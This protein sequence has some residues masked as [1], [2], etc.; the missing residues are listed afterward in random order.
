MIEA[1]LAIP[2]GYSLAEETL[3]LKITQILDPE[4]RDN[5]AGAVLKASSLLGAFIV[6]G[7]AMAA[8]GVWKTSVPLLSV[9]FMN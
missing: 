2:L 1:S 6:L 8:A 4:H 5:Q 9:N 7:G 3:F